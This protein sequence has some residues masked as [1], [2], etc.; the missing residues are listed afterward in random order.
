M[1][2]IKNISVSDVNDISSLLQKFPEVQHIDLLHTD[3]TGI[4]Y[5]LH[6]KFEY[7]VNGIMTELTIPVVDES[8]W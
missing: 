5:T 4:G 2:K 6:V 1:N 8:N 7:Q 3:T